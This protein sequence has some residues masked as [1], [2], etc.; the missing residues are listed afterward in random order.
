MHLEDVSAAAEFIVMAIEA[1]RKDKLKELDF[2]LKLST[3][4]LWILP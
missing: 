1:G 2:S 4:V 3:P